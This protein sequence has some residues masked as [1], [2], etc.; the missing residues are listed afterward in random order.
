MQAKNLRHIVPS[1]DLVDIAYANPK[2]VQ[3]VNP[4]TT[5][6]TIYTI[7][8]SI[9][10]Q[11]VRLTCE[12][13]GLSYADRSLNIREFENLQPWYIAINPRGLL[14]TL[15]FGD[16]AI[17]DS[18][19]IMLFIDNYFAGPRLGP[20]EPEHRQVMIDWLR[21]FD[22]FPVHYLSFR[23]QMERAKRGAP[24]YWTSS[25]HDN[26]LRAMERHPEHRELYEL[27]LV[28]WDDIIRSVN[29][30]C[31]MRDVEASAFGLTDNLE[32]VLSADEYLIG[33]HFSLADITA[34]ALLVRVQCGCGLSLYGK[35]LRPRL[36]AYVERLKRRASYRPGLL[37]PYDQSSFVS[38]EGDCWFPA[39]EAA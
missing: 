32:L 38:L 1:Q 30:D 11:R 27:K 13:K 19:T 6:I 4:E 24:D 26:V 28:E 20:V 10:S 29:D 35:G 39:Q 5:S 22:A 15:T 17:F 7:P 34:L 9:C 2:N 31:L 37:A 12:E 36:Y 23:W 25:M 16:R 18:L 21:R 33:K 14:P 8:T 3:P